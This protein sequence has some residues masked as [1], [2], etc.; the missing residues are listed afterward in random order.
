MI[1]IIAAYDRN[2]LIGW[3]GSMPWHIPGELRRFRT[4]TQGKTQTVLSDK[5]VIKAYLGE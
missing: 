3:G 5:E 2:R 1:S 4:L